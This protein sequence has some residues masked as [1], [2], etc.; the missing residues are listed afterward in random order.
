[1]KINNKNLLSILLLG[2]SSGFPLALLTGTLTARYTE[3]GLSIMTIGALSLIQLPY[4]LKPLWAPLVDRF[5]LLPMARR[6]S[7]LLLTQILIAL[8]LFVMSAIKAAV[9]PALL[10]YVALG[11]AFFAASFDISYD[12]YRTDLLPE[13]ERGAGAAMVALGYRLALLV[14]GAFALVLANYIG[15]RVTYLIM[16]VIMLSLTVVTALSADPNNDRHIATGLK[17]IWRDPLADLFKRRNLILL[18]VFIVLYKLCDAFA[19]S[20]STTFLLR[21]L[22]FSLATIGAAMKTVSLVATLLGALLGGYMMRYISLWQALFYFGILQALSNSGYLLL[23]IIGKH[24]YVMIG[25]V[26]IEYFAG[27]LVAVAFVAYLT[28]MC[29]TKFSA[30]QYALLSAL[31][32]LGRVLVGPVAAISEV[33]YGWVGYFIISILL[34]LPPLVLLLVWRQKI[35][36]VQPECMQSSF[37]IASQ[38][39]R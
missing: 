36:Q 38:A 29:N 7:W 21:G 14:S 8:S 23:A 6:R 39:G 26:F 27:G 24:F 34:G 25:A 30:T 2:F 13:H 5:K 11:V 37:E 16:A 9:H 32:S 17:N 1:M 33:H 18:L 4:L 28:S 31:A 3:A 35:S 15:F 22:H 10:A 19:L 12:A 20:L